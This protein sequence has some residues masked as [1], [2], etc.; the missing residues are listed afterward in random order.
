MYICSLFTTA[1]QAALQFLEQH[2]IFP[3]STSSYDVYDENIA[4]YA[5]VQYQE[6]WPSDWAND[7]TEALFMSVLVSIVEGPSSF[8]FFSP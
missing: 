3:C 4:C 5:L 7:S 6:A 1:Y 8:F 2:I